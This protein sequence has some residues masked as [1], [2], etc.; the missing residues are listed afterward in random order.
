MIRRDFIKSGTLAAG[1]LITPFPLFAKD[2]K[3]K[4]AILGT[5]WW[6]TD[7]ILAHA[8]ISK[9]FDIVALCDVNS[10]SLENAAGKCS[11]QSG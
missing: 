11:K 3:V 7:M 8:L 1:T 10:V 5:G 4:L 2:E 6:G 9:Q